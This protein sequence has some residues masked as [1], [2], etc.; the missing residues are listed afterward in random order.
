MSKSNLHC[1]FTQ[2]R[3]K[4]NTFTQNSA[5]KPE[6]VYVRTAGAGGRDGGCA[7]N[8]RFHVVACKLYGVNTVEH[9]LELD[10]NVF[11]CECDGEM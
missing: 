1:D 4:L 2:K 9:G 6:L 10:L 3:M 8:V 5:V 11:V 7:V